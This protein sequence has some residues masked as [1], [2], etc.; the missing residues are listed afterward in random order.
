MEDR[1]GSRERVVKCNVPL[2]KKE[3]NKIG[4]IMW[5]TTKNM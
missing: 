4:C 1:D 3:E 5:K 2:R